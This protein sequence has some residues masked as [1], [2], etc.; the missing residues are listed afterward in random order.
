M[1]NRGPTFQGGGREEVEEEQEKDRGGYRC[2]VWWHVERRKGSV[3]G[4]GDVAEF[5]GGRS[6]MGWVQ[7]VA[8]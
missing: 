3:Y 7:G 5:S 2:R 6:I 1:L 4:G 8:Q